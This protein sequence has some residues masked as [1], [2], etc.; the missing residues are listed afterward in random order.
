MCRV[1][2][3]IAWLYY[4]F[5]GFSQSSPFVTRS[6]NQLQLDGHPFYFVG[7]NA[8]YLMEEA[9]R[10]DTALVL[11]LFE[12][13]QQ[14]R[15]TVLRTWGF[16]DS[17]DSTNPAVIQ[18]RP[19][20]YNERALRALDFV[21]FQA[22]QHGMKV[23][24]PLVNSWDDYGGMNQY[25]SWRM[26]G[27]N[28]QYPRRHPQNDLDAIVTGARGQSYRVA[29]SESFGH[30]DFYADDTI[31]VWYKSYVSFLLHR[32]NTCSNVTYKDD[33]TILAW[34]LANE[35]RSSDRS[36][37]IVSRWMEDVASF[38]KQID[39]NHLVGTGEEGFDNSAAGYSLQAY[40]GQTWLFDGTE[41]V[42][43]SRNSGLSCI[44]FASI[45]LYPEPWGLTTGAGNAW[46]RDHIHL[47]A[48]LHKPLVLGEFGAL[49][50]QSATYDSWLATVLWEDGSG[51]MVWQLLEGGRNNNDGYGIRCPEAGR[52]C[53]VLRSQGEQFASKSLRGT[54]VPPSSFALLQNYP[55][56]FNGQTTVSYDLYADSRV[57]LSLFNTLG[58]LMEIFVDGFQHAGTRKELL[59]AGTLPS[60]AYF[61]RADVQPVEGPSISAAR[62]L[63][64]IR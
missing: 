12:S 9:A 38:I 24:L 59:E 26:Y 42:A 10:G 11:S 56:P 21:L 49:A 13:A 48:G 39:P 33:P 45:H 31:R 20:A 47:A 7:T 54:L 40:G 27:D 61:Y 44:D 35:P 19:G 28:G 30:D 34:E 18:W 51:A 1:V 60:G 8:Y 41:G 36:G 57:R 6:G 14:L 64:I 55:N 62:K 22:A 23:V 17:S 25:V 15:M 50:G 63:L 2:L 46:I 52:V 3:V 29:L 5:P 4:P 58:E 37:L 16:F 43:W 53:S 32:R